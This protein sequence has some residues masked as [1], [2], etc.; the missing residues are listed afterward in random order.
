MTTNKVGLGVG[1]GTVLCEHSGRCRGFASFSIFAALPDGG[2]KNKPCPATTTP[3]SVVWR[4]VVKH[5]K[6]CRF[7]TV[8]NELPGICILLQYV[9]LMVLVGTLGYLFY[10]QE[11]IS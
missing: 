5:C 3:A 2:K 10:T 6:L 4:W 8:C 1:R 11:L 9:A 7:S